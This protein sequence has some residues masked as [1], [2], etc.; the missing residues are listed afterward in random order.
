MG[1]TRPVLSSAEYLASFNRTFDLFLRMDERVREQG[2]EPDA[3]EA[4]D[5]EFRNECE[6][7]ETE[8]RWGHYPAHR[9]DQVHENWEV[10]LRFGR[11]NV[12]R[13]LF[14]PELRLRIGSFPDAG[15]GVI[16]DDETAH[17]RMWALRNAELDSTPRRMREILRPVGLRCGIRGASRTV[18]IEELDALIGRML[19]DAAPRLLRGKR[20]EDGEDDG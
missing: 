14:Y 17:W 19:L 4:K 10:Q 13:G 16:W 1:K 5:G 20:Y 2:I 11:K 18:T 9:Y 7:Y 3:T 6:V 8:L 12:R 15:V